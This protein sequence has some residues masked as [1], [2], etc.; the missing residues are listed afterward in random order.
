MSMPQFLV[1]IDDK[2]GAI[3]K[4]VE[5][6]Q[7]HLT[8]VQKNQAIRVGGMFNAYRPFIVGP[9][10]AKEPTP[11]DPNPS[12]VWHYVYRYLFMFREVPSLWRQSHGKQL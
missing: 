10:F 3:G 6:R 7:Q 2:P 4:R 11:E 12:N 5:F 1:L 9:L 8:N